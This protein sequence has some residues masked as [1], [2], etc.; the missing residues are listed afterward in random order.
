[1]KSMVKKIHYCW[2]GGKPKPDS[3]NSCIASW[4]RYL[5]DYEI[6]E[7]N[8]QNFDIKSHPYVE[9]AYSDKKW[10]FVSDYVRL[11]ALYD[12]GGLYLDTDLELVRDVSVL[13]TTRFV[14][15]VER[16]GPFYSAM[17]AFIFSEPRHP[18]LAD[19]LVYY[20]TIHESARY[21]PNT[22]MLREILETRYDW[23]FD[24]SNAVLEGGVSIYNSAVLCSPNVWHRSYAIHHFNGSWT[25]AP[26]RSLSIKAYARLSSICPL[27]MTWCFSR[28]LLFLRNV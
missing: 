2:F 6:I 16:N 15:G 18:L 17:T 22:T 24:D 5:P 14:I 10:A 3:I 28:M 25:T 7:W 1:M 11:K 9:R 26:G 20:N 8:E 19:C 27:R 4:E 23:T 21:V 12:F 13:F